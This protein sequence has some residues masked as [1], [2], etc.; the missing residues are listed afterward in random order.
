MADFTAASRKPSWLLNRNF[1][2]LW[3]GQSVS[4][5][6]DWFFTMTLLLWIFR[7]LA[8]GQPWVGLA[9]GGITI[10]T[11]LP[12]LFVG[13]LAGVFIDRWDRRLTMIWMDF[14]RAVLI[15]LLLL[16]TLLVP[17]HI[18]QLIIL[19]VIVVLTSICTQ[20][21]NPAHLTVV[22]E[23][24]PAP[25]RVQAMALLRQAFFLSSIFGPTLATPLYLT[26]GVQWALALNA[27]SF[28]ASGL[29]VL[30]MRMPKRAEGTD[31]R[32][33]RHFRR[34]FLAGLR[35]YVGNRTLMVLLIT[36]MLAN[37]AG[38]AFNAISILFVIENLHT[39]NSLT[40]FF[41]AAYGVGALIGLPMMPLLVRHSGEGRVLWISLLA[42]GSFLLM[43]ARMSAVLPGLAGFFLLGLG[44]AGVAV[45]TRPLM[46]LVTPR[47]FMGRMQA[48]SESISTASALL[49]AT[50]ASSL[51]T[52]LHQLHAVVLGIVFGPNDT[53][54][55]GIGVVMI[56]A[57]VYTMKTLGN[58][59]S[60]PE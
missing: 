6:G 31:I 3:A 59:R 16:V 23:I 55:T 17:S 51:V 8:R 26:F 50:L 18:W 43:L 5:L 56:V 19:Y 52:T 2:W 25:Q 49:G 34:E 21:F 60:A 24:V 38:V 29:A 10:A 20:F 7:Q 39:F 30:A 9:V 28:L 33:E 42:W 12:A 22:A 45:T 54:F 15:A 53:I 41:E 58:I 40:G 44:N 57:G 36:R 4:L 32:Q 48:F 27:L 11:V 35:F 14:I 1:A 37:M 46:M 13:P 47:E